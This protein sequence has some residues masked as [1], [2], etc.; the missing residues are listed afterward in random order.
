MIDPSG[1]PA[2]SME[3]KDA[4]DFIDRSNLI[5]NFESNYFWKL[6]ETK[7]SESGPISCLRCFISNAINEKINVMFKKFS[8]LYEIELQDM[9]S[10]VLNDSGEKYFFISNSK[11]GKKRI[12]F[13]RENL[14]NLDSLRSLPFS[15]DI[16]LGFNPKLSNLNTWAKNKVQANSELNSY[17]ASCGCLL[18]TPWSLIADSSPR[19]IKTSWERCGAGRMKLKE[20]LTLHS[21]YINL[22]RKSK[23]E[24]KQKTGKISGWIPDQDFLNKLNPIQKDL[25][26]L[27]LIDKAIRTYISPNFTKQFEEGEE[28]KLV[29]ED[30][31][32]DYSDSN[33]NL[34]KKIS[35]SLSKNGMIITKKFIEA[36]K[37][38]WIKDASR[39]L[40]WKL[41]SEGLSQREIAT[42]CAHK[43][44]WVS[45]LLPEKK[46]AEMIAQEAA[47]ELTAYKEFNQI[48][49][50]IESLDRMVLELRNH[51]LNTELKDGKS[52]LR[53]FVCEILDK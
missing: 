32:E 26:N 43:Q 42:K 8:Q 30:F 41:Y 36:D 6:S 7:S 20:V 13:S 15:V 3:M 2:R 34:F 52:F 44:G 22:Y 21:S 16:I 38:K 17:L 14:L 27:L 40:A 51:L 18:Q 39:E 5:D 45:K 53:S 47:I 49:N 10:F 48:K 31:S 28:E 37:K 9:L 25:S 23:E 35:N 46:I 50:D 11:E 1:K 12:M 33:D 4:K 24:Y 19:R 29:S